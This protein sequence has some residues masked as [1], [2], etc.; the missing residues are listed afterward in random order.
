M[1]LASF[2]DE[3]RKKN[4]GK[5]LNEF[6]MKDLII[7]SET[8]EI[9]YHGTGIYFFKGNSDKMVYVGKASSKSFTERISCHFD[10]RK[11]AWFNSLLKHKEFP[12][13]QGNT[14]DTFEYE[15]RMAYDNLKLVLVNFNAEFD[16]I[17]KLESLMRS[18]LPDLINKTKKETSDNDFVKTIEILLS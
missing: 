16:K 11:F 15:A 13:T 14:S 10:P 8:D 4:T 7:D 12:Y 18:C 17:G 6:L 2:C 3:I 5:K 9:I 1:T